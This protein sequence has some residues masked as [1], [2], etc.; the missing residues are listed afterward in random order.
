MFLFFLFVSSIASRLTSIKTHPF[1]ALVLRCATIYLKF[2]KQDFF[3]KI[4]E[5]ESRWNDLSAHASREFIACVNFFFHWIFYAAFESNRKSKRS[6][7]LS[8]LPFCNVWCKRIGNIFAENIF[9]M[10]STFARSLENGYSLRNIK[11][12]RSNNEICKFYS[13][14]RVFFSLFFR[15]LVT[16]ERCCSSFHVSLPLCI[17]IYS[18]WNRV[19]AFSSIFS[20]IRF[21]IYYLM[22]I[23]V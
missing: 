14:Y 7:C 16:R 6:E 15:F 18:F 20:C 12:V 10:L 19:I 4:S 2:T 1:P 17:S 23:N 13:F 5:A 9:E 22:R 3:Q 8:S 21:C 11:Q